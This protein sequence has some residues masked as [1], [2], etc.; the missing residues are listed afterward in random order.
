MKRRAWVF[1]FSA[2]VVLSGCGRRSKPRSDEEL[3]REEFTKRHVEAE[4]LG[5]A[6]A[7]SS[8]WDLHLDEGL[9][10]IMFDPPG[11]PRNK[12]IRWIGQLVR[13]RLRRHG[14]KPMKFEATGWANVEVLQTRPSVTLYVAH[15]MVHEGPVAENGGFWTGGQ[16][17]A[18]WFG[19]D[20]WITAELVLSSVSFHWGEPPDLKVA[21]L[22]SVGYREIE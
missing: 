13:V 5:R 2:A 6:Y 21:L 22:T 16:I 10:V 14:D 12:A 9:S 15:R 11:D 19:N 17:P 1:L 3:R 4:S 18:E 7:L 8:H 20:E